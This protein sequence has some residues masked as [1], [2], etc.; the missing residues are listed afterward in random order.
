MSWN[1]YFPHH[2][3]PMVSDMTDIGDVD[4]TFDYGEPFRPFEQLLAVLPSASHKLLPAAF[5]VRTSRC[6]CCMPQR[7]VA[8]PCGRPTSYGAPKM[9]LNTAAAVWGRKG[10]S[11]TA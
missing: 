5:T 6:H 1:W 9:Y 4:V 11:M 10:C 7:R 3:A 2:Y 8:P